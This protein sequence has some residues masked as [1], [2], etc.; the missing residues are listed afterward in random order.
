VP[1]SLL[2]QAA[3]AGAVG[4]AWIAS[5]TGAPQALVRALAVVLLAGLLIHAA[6]IALEA[7]MPHPTANAS[8]G[9]RALLRGEQARLFWGV[10]VGVGVILPVVLLA[11]ALAQASPM[12]GVVAIAA[13]AAFLGLAAYE[14]AFVQAG[15]AAPLS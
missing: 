11:V 14:H 6:I 8:W 10:A 15:Q 3:I 13:V 4:L 2:A 1:V 9:V 12:M 7:L 5:F